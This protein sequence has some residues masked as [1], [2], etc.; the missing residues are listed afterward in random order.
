MIHYLTGDATRP[1]AEGPA[2]IAHICNDKGLWGKGF[3]LALSKRWR[4]PRADFV[5]WFKDANAPEPLALGG[6][7]LVQVEDALWVA[8]M[9]AQHDIR[10]QGGVPPIRY[11]ALETCLHKLCRLALEKGASVHMPRIGCGLAGGTWDRV[12]PMLVNAGLEV[13]VYALPA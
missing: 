10:S 4:A 6:V 3:V 11:G 5:A 12:E 7:Q 1:Q 2:I 13:F 8:N 9:V